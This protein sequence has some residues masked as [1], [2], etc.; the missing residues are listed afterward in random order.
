MAF[1]KV[2][3][4]PKQV[5]YFV[6]NILKNYQ[7]VRG[8]CLVQLKQHLKWKPPPT[9]VLKL[10]IDGAMFVD[11]RRTGVGFLLRD[12][13]GELIVATSKAEFDVENLETIELLAVFRGI[14]LCAS[15]GIPNLIVE[16]YSL[17]GNMTAHKLDR[18]AWNVVDCEN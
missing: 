6:L 9:D 5:A 10:N 2:V 17:E 11:L 14:Q 7:E 8:L 16:S 1:D 18:N 12:A 3:I 15:R 4:H 13:K